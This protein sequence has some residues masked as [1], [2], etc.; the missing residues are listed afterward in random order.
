LELEGFVSP[1]FVLRVDCSKGTYVRS[2]VHDIGERLGCGAHV[3]ELRR[4][5]SGPFELERAMTL[6]RLLEDPQEVGTQLLSIEELLQSWPHLEIEASEVER[7]RSGVPLLRIQQF[8]EENEL[9]NRRLVLAHGETIH[10]LIETVSN[11]AFEYL[12]VL[13]R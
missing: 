1:D 12:R 10:A 5:A 4:L 8:I 13:N 7:V 9:F 3:T 6:D 2:L 11:K